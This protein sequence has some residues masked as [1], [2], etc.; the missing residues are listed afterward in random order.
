MERKEGRNVSID[1][2][3]GVAAW[4]VVLGHFV[5]GKEEYHR[6]FNVIYSFHMPLFMFL[7]G[8]TAV[9]PIGTVRETGIIWQD[10]L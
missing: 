3:K 1:V 4:L 9:V 5:D 10:G 7:A 2:L 6:L 8:Y